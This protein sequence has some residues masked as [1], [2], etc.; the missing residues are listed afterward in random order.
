MKSPPGD[1]F[2]GKNR[3]SGMCKEYGLMSRPRKPLHVLFLLDV[4]K[5]SHGSDQEI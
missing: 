1:H 2:L 5:L 4:T 3:C